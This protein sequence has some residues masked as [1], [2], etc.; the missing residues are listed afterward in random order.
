M[1]IVTR[2]GACGETQLQVD[3]I[4]QEYE[5]ESEGGGA[6]ERIETDRQTERQRERSHGCKPEQDSQEH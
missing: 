3:E 2:K 6:R 1:Q 5:C 4:M